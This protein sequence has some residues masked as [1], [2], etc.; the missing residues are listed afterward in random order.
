MPLCA[1]CMGTFGG[2][3]ITLLALAVMGQGRRSRLPSWRLSLLL[4]P[5]VAFWAADGANSTAD[6]FLGHPLLYPPSN[7]LRFVAG[8][9]LGLVLGVLIYPMYHFIMWKNTEDRRI[10]EEGWPVSMLL[11]VVAVCAA[12]VISWHTAPFALWVA[13]IVGAVGAVLALTNGMLAVVLFHREG[14]VETWREV[15]PYL[16]LG[17][18]AAIVETGTLAL[19]R[20]LII[21]V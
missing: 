20:H 16:L 7:A 13:L 11:L 2:T 6:F 10:L 5:L 4:A 9:G 8:L 1:R 12:L 19:V 3:V 15:V 18:A 14:M 17:L 21:G